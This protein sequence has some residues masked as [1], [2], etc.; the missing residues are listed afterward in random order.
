MIRSSFRIRPNITHRR[1]G[2]PI[3]AAQRYRSSKATRKAAKASQ[4]SQAPSSITPA[5]QKPSGFQ[6]VYVL[7]GL[8]GFAG[9][10]AGLTIRNFVDPSLPVPGSREDKLALAALTSDVEQL[11]VV[12]WMRS[13]TT[14]ADSEDDGK[15]SDW[16]ELDV[17]TNIT[18][19]KEDEGKSTRTLTLHTLAGS[20]G[21]GIQRAFWNVDTKELVAVVWIGT[22]L[23]GWPTMAH[24][25]AIATIFEDCMSR[26][27][28]G[29]DASISA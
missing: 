2:P 3:C 17:K 14:P 21:L 15:K 8:L 26:M 18:E 7:Y 27:V 23:G 25:G 4:A 22:A 1:A 19:S 10:S 12:Q 9:V 28:A 29:P 5:P 16:I 6:W 11:E 20:K 24:G 13:Q